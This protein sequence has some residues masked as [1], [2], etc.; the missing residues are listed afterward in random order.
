MTLT[1]NNPALAATSV[2]DAVELL[3]ERGLRASAARRLVLEALFAADA[4]ISAERVASG[5]E[6]RVPRSDLAS[7]YRNLETLEAAGLVRHVHLGHSPGLYALA[8]ATDREY[9]VC[10]SCA[11]VRAVAS[12]ELDEVRE[13][14]RERFGYVPHFTHFPLVGLCPNCTA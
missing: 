14:V 1:K 13:S 11:A 10:E 4:P 3:R 5:V 8:G 12:T 7:V 6:G 9:L 2:E